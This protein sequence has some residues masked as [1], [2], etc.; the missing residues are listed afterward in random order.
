MCKKKSKLKSILFKKENNDNF[1]YPPSYTHYAVTHRER[2][3]SGN[4]SAIPKTSHIF[5]TYRFA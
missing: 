3:V 1:A 2:L 4:L 5:P